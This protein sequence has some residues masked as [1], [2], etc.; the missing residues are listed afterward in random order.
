MLAGHSYGGQVNLSF[1]SSPM[2][3]MAKKYQKGLYDIESSEKIKLYVN[4][5]IGTSHFPIRFRIPPEITVF[6]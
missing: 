5:G 6:D 4:S 3:S 1:L 2:T